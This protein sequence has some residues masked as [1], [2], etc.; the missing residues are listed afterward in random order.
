[1]TTLPGKV[2]PKF[3][4]ATAWH[5]RGAELA[6]WILAHLVN[7]TDVW[8]GY[9]RDGQVTRRGSLSHP[10]VVRHCRAGHAGDIVGVHMADASNRSKGGALDFDQ[11]GDDSVRA[12]ANRRAALY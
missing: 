4:D 9:Y 12:E 8:G 2:N 11:K 1:M 5:L 3:F 6:D 7:R 10:L